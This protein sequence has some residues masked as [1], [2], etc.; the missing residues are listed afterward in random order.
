[1]TYRI[2]LAMGCALALSGCITCYERAEGAPPA[3]FERDREDC[4]AKRTAAGER[5]DM[6]AKRDTFMEQC[7]AEK[8]WQVEQR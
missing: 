8:G 1:M 5:H 7:M 4:E 3:N 2:L 6:F